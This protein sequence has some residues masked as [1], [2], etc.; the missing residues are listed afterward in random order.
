MDFTEGDIIVYKNGKYIVASQ[1][2]RPLNHKLAHSLLKT[3]RLK[4]RVEIK[5]GVIYT[6]SQP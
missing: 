6:Y 2:H 1:M 3:G 4:K 5:G